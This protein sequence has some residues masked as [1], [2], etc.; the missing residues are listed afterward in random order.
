MEDVRYG[1][2]QLFVVI[3][4]DYWIAFEHFHDFSAI[5]FLHANVAID[6]VAVAD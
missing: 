4:I 1:G 3:Q 2:D 5:A 6:A